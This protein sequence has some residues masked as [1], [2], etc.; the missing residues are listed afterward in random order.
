MTGCFE[1]GN[2]TLG[3]IKYRE[4]LAD[5]LLASQEGLSPMQEVNSC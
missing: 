5:E 3:S 2:A 4:F 1:Y